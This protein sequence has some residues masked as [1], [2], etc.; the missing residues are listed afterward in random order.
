MI[1]DEKA[2]SNKEVS[3]DKKARLSFFKKKVAR[4]IT[5]GSYFRTF[6]SNSTGKTPF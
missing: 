2:N 1:R 4:N 3:D 6:T 5:K